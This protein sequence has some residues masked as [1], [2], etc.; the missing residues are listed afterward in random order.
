MMAGHSKFKNIMHR[1][2]AQ[3]AKRG[4]A[5]ARTVRN[6]TIAARSNPDPNTNAA[7]RTAISVA[8]TLNMPKDNIEKAIMSAT[9]KESQDLESVIYE[10]YGPGGVALMIEAVTDNKNRTVSMVRSTLSKYGGTLGETGSV[11]FLFDRL[12]LITYQKPTIEDF[13]TFFDTACRQGAYD[14]SMEEHTIEVLSLPGD[15]HSLLTSLEETFGSPQQA[16]LTW[17][18]KTQLPALDEKQSQQLEKIFEKLEE[19]ND[20]QN[21][22]VNL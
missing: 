17:I 6:I 19:N 2:G 14:C 8:K 18:A 3:D 7:L 11:R 21:I 12:G 16:S 1:K 10:G 13:E 22:C 9:L 20:I 5:F 4:K 15:F